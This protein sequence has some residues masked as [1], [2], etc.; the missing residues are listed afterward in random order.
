MKLIWLKRAATTGVDPICPHAPRM[1]GF[2]ANSGSNRMKGN[3]A[4]AAIVP[5]SL[6]SGKFSIRGKGDD[7]VSPDLFP[8]AA[9]GGKI[10]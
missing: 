8:F 3:S 5:P 1:N 7:R 4:N 10:D 6:A 9:S 2:R